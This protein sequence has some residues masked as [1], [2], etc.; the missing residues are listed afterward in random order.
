[1][2]LPGEQKVI[3]RICA[4]RKERLSVLDNAKQPT[5]DGVRPR[6]EEWECP[7]LYRILERAGLLTLPRRPKK[8]SADGQRKQ[9]PTRGWC[10]ALSKPLA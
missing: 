4:M 7:T 8:A 1:V 6:G 2:T 9:G 5:A 10:D 3:H